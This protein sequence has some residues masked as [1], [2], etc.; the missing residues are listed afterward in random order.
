MSD[1]K[2]MS[3]TLAWRSRRENEILG[4]SDK[5]FGNS[6]RFY[7]PDIESPQFRSPAKTHPAPV[8]RRIVAGN[9]PVSN[10]HVS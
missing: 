10:P 2:L 7:K 8:A 9:E 4:I 6:R 1:C 3:M 5:I